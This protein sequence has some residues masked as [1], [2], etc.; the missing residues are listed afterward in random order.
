M[1][2]A[3]PHSPGL[4][5]FRGVP[6]DLPSSEKSQNALH[7]FIHSL[8]DEYSPSTYCVRDAVPGAGGTRLNST[9]SLPDHPRF[10]LF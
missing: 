8:F 4:I 2:T 7:S 9:R 6:G 3:G 1:V 10:G 5:R